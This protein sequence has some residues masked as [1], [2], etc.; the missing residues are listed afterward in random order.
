MGWEDFSG[1]ERLQARIVASRPGAW[2]Y[3]N[4]APHIDRRLLR[5]SR[6]RVGFGGR[7]SGILT[8]VGRKSGAVRETP[9]AFMR[10]G[11]RIVLIASRGGDTRNPGWYHNLKANPDVSFTALGEKRDYVAREAEGEERE[12]LWRKINSEVYPGYDDYQQRA[13]SRRIPVVVLEPGSGGST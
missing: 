7:R 5:V 4:V 9:L 13:G 8:N 11:D 1:L 10:D 2:F 3:V 12:R 6:G